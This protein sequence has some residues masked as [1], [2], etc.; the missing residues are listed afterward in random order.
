MN[1]NL[2][3]RRRL[4]AAGVGAAIAAP[5]VSAQQIPSEGYV[6][7][8][9]AT[10]CC[11]GFGDEDFRY[12]FESIPKLGVGYVE[13]N[14]WY[15]RNLTPRGLQ[16]IRHR[17]DQANLTPISIQASSFGGG[18]NH[19]V[20]KEVSR[21]LWLI[22]ACD[23]L[24]C[25]MIKC[26]G[27]RRGQAGGLD[28]LVQVLKA[29]APE[30]ER[31]GKRIVLENHHRNV[32]EFPDDYDY[33]FGKIDSPSIGMC[34]DM[35]HF[36]RSGVSMEPLIDRWHKKIYEIDVK[37]ADAVDG[38]KFVRFG[39]GIVDCEG[40][41]AQCIERGYQGYLVL[42][43]SLIDR[44]TMLDDLHAGLEITRRFERNG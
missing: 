26:T 12:A 42:E 28:S 19:E 30:A 16:S 10:I 7:T 22:E 8:A 44:A 20:S 11:D 2:I 32:I 43:L 17:S 21:L 4:L 24:G 34:F 5:A 25:D 37:D 13:F 6:R 31:R 29:I 35:G 3:N 1:S 27:G 36:A 41:I 38:K 23:R 9:I 39:T 14:C 33:I 40:I 18:S 15:P